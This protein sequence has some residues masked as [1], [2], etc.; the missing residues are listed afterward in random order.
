MKFP[1][2]LACNC[3][4]GHFWGPMICSHTTNIRKSLEKQ[5][6]GKASPRDSG[7]SR[8]TRLSHMKAMRWV[9]EGNI[10]ARSSVTWNSTCVFSFAIANDAHVFSDLLV[11]S[12]FLLSVIKEGRRIRRSGGCRQPGKSR[13]WAQQRRGWRSSGHRREKREGRE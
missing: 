10:S 3:P 4:A 11:M 2:L 6:R 5:K 1:K 12:S 9:L 8:T 7:R 13:C